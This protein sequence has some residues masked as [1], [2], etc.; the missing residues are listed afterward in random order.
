MQV[1]EPH[2]L[3]QRRKKSGK[4]KSVILPIFVAAI[5]GLAS[6]FIYQ[7]Y[8]SG[9]SALSVA[10]Q[11][12]K[13]QTETV[14]KTG[15]LK[16]FTGLEFKDL[17]NS[18]AYPNTQEISEETPI[19]GDPAADRHIRDLAEAR[20]YLP[21]SA[22]VS[23]VFRNVGDSFVLQEKAATD[24]LKLKSAA[25]KDSLELSLTAAYRSA[26]DQKNIFLGK[27][28]TYGI[29]SS[30]IASSKYDVQIDEILKTTA[31]PGYSR[32][33]TGYTVDIS[34]PSNPVTFENSTCFDWLKKNNYKNAKLSGWIPSYP[35]GA[36]QQGPDPEPWEYVW[37]GKETLL[38]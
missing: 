25:K 12:Q 31:L 34:C 1:I 21:R 32:H 19:T 4:T 3:H 37:V 14:P 11:P 16:T 28:K 23:D 30:L 2:Q 17:Y 26:D 9:D 38:Q 8:F 18:I 6:Y 33:H 20:G 13:T 29:Q 35:A 36:G 5:I 15:T 7:N 24:W 27:L 22:P 10:E